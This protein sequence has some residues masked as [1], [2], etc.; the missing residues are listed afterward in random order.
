MQSSKRAAYVF[1]EAARVCSIDTS[2]RR[3]SIREN[4]TM[5]RTIATIPIT[6]S[7]VCSAEEFSSPLVARCPLDMASF[8]DPAL[9]GPIFEY[10]VDIRASRASRG[11]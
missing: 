6:N 4:H 2:A 3:N 7:S 1:R 5:Q 10:A 8:E 9:R 11:A